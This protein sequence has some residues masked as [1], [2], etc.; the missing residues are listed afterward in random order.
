MRIALGV[1]YDGTLFYGWQIQPDLRTVQA[2]LEK[3]IAEVAD[4]AV[5]VICAGRTDTGVHA[6]GQV[7]H[8]DT[9]AERDEKAWVFGVNSFLPDDVAVK[10]SRFVADDFHAR[11]SAMVRSYRYIICNEKIKPALK[12]QYETWHPQPLDEK[13]MQEASQFLIGKHDFSS[14]QDANCQSK[15][16]YRCIK[17]INIT[18][19]G[20]LVIIDIKANAF[21]H[22]MVRNIVG[23]LFPIG[24][25]KQSPDWL[26]EVLEAKDR[27]VAGVTAKP[28]GLYLMLIEY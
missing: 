18:R 6:Y 16:P 8:F 17:E 21:L 22:H 1:E 7:I 20:G 26:Q 2:E 11:F 23:T 5:R 12:R 10:W 9:K 4:E 14:F 27:R 28:N 19:N 13:R 25:G 24:E 3:A 15:S